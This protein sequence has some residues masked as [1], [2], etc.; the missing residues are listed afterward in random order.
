MCDIG[1]LCFSECARDAYKEFRRKKRVIS[2][3]VNLRLCA[4]QTAEMHRN[5]K[6]ICDTIDP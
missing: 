2:I 3:L 1:I 4:T 5:E 6:K